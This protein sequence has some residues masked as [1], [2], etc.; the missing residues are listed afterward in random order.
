VTICFASN[1]KHKHEEIVGALTGTGIALLSLSDIGCAEELPETSSTLEGN[2]LQKARYVLDNFQVPC[3]AD[4]TGLEVDALDG[5]PG[6]YS[7]R[8]AGSQRNSVDNI[9]L[10]LNNMA[11]ADNRSARFRTVIA[12]VGL[13]TEPVVFEGVVPGIITPQPRGAGGFGYDPVFV[14]RGNNRTFAEMTL[15]E[16]NVLSHRAIAVKKLVAH[17]SALSITS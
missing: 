12:L 2:A 14:P 9:E 1:N 10:L 5:Q 13:S 3:F 7:A 15:G 8:Y 4:D 11:T 16:K 6:V 17:L